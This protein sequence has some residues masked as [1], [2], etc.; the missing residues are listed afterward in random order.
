MS[1]GNL[2]G[3]FV[4]QALGS[5]ADAWMRSDIQHCGL[6]EITLKRARG[7]LLLRHNDTGHLPPAL[8][9]FV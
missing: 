2:I 4:G 1:S 9:S 3:Y 7:P 8:R 5:P 6:T